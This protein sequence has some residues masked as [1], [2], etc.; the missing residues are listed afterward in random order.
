MDSDTRAA[1]AVL[2][3]T[4][5]AGFARADRY[6]ELQQAQFL[7]WRDELRGDLTDLRVR[8]EALTER[9]ARLEQQVADLE[10][11][12]ALFRDFVTHEIAGIRLELR[13][14]RA[15]DDQTDQFRR[16]IA[17]LAARVDRLEQGD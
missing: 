4:M 9:V 5:N 3:E 17:T 13:E 2:T 14:L 16:D 1:F 6:F 11:K 15:R 8:L 10:Q 7:E 12:L